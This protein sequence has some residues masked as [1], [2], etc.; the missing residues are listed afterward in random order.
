MFLCGLEAQIATDRQMIWVLD[1]TSA[2][3]TN[4]LASKGC[5]EESQGFHTMMSGFA[6]KLTA[7]REEKKNQIIL[8]RSFS[9]SKENE[10]W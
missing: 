2:R 4:F 7:A 9:D 8:S 3:T 10:I 1:P 6:S 5:G